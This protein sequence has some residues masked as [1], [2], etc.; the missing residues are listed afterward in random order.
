MSR[1]PEAHRQVALAGVLSLL[2]VAPSA[3]GERKNFFG[4]HTLMDGGAHVSEGMNWTRH[5]VG[6]G[7]Y[8]FDWVRGD[9][10]KWV[11]V[12]VCMCVS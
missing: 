3:A 10:G 1:F 7:G 6:E 9:H 11:C 5:M 12:Y 8:V 4:M 2:L